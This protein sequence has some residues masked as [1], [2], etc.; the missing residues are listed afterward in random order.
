MRKL[1]AEHRA[2]LS[3]AKRRYYSSLN[4]AKRPYKRSVESSVMPDI[5]KIKQNALDIIEKFNDLN[6]M[7]GEI[8]PEIIDKE[9]NKKDIKY[10]YKS[11]FF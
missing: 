5:N 6:R 10:E 1:T 2:K 7:Y 9:F 4:G 8:T 3:E 11:N